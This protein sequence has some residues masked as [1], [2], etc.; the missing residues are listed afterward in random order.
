MVDLK[1]VKKVYC[2]G[3]KG[4]G[5]SAVAVML[6][7]RGLVVSGSDTNEKF[8]TDQ[9]LKRSEIEFKENFAVEN[10]PLD[11]DLVVYSTAYNQEN[12]VESQEALRRNIPMRSY[13]EILGA[14]FAEKMGIAVCGTHGKTTTSAMLADVLKFVGEDPSAIIGSQVSAWESGSL[15]GT[16]KVFVIEADEY[17]NKLRYYN[18]FG[19]ILTSVDFDHPDFFP[20]PEDYRKVFQDFVARIPRHGFLVACGESMD[21]LEVAKSAKCEALSYGFNEEC[22]YRIF[23]AGSKKF[24]LT[25]REENLGEFEIQLVG[26]H[27]VLNASAVIAVC[28]KLKIDLEKVRAGLRSFQGTTRRF[29]QIGEKNGAILIDD[30]AHHPEEI[31]ATL[32]GAREMYPEKNIITVFHPHTFTR[33]KALLQ[34]F[35]QSFDGASKV[36]VIDIYGSAREV[37]GGVSSKELVELINKY[38]HEKA[39]YLATIPEAIDYLSGKIGA[40]DVVISMGAGNVWEV[41][42]QLKQN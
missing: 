10:I 6:Q 42:H 35:A 29:E 25:Y 23:D 18:P 4:A 9:I 39:E 37:Q 14:L 38:N 13:P 26:K 30:Y 27:N 7:K 33:T 31:K 1:K 15:T 40:D 11:A 28:H 17:Q 19:V 16:G 22:D 3:I 41:T 24:S 36:I 21:V 32:Q 2:I 34:E 12:N 20:T 5:L 8:Y